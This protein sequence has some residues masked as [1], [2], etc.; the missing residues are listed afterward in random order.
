MGMK[1]NQLVPAARLRPGDVLTARLIP[2]TTVEKTYGRLV[3][4]E[5]DDPEFR[6]VD[7]PTFWGD[8]K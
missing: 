3:R 7:L 4:I 6:L 8:L 1:D 5:L 2:W